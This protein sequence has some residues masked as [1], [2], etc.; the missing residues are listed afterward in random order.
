MHVNTDSAAAADEL[1][2]RLRPALCNGNLQDA[3][4]WV[5]QKWTPGQLLGLLENP[6]TDARKVAA[7]ALGMIGDKS[8]VRPLAVALHDCDT[9]VSQIAEHAL[10]AIWFRLGAAKAVCLVKCGNMHLEHGNYECA[11]EKFSQAIGEDRT[12]AEAHNQRAIAYYLTEQ[13]GKSIEDCRAALELMPQHFGAM[14]GMG[15]CHAHRGEWKD[16]RKCYRL[17]LA[18]HP[19]L[20]GVGSSL[21]QIEQL[22]K[23]HPEVG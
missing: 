4:T 19:R 10:W 18:I 12:F 20:D 23:E 21:E 5:Q 2:A 11:I 8:A 1:V 9:M 14:A 15:H 22:M 3:L 7:L 13:Y 17:A 16:A 6:C